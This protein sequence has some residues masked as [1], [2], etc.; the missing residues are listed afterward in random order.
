MFLIISMME[1]SFVSQEQ[2]LDSS[3][4]KLQLFKGNPMGL[5]RF[6]F[7]FPGRGFDKI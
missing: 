1:L 7:G 4:C 5:R 6:L 3:I 2:E